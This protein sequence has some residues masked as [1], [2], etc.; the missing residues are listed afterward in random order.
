MLLPSGYD[1]EADMHLFQYQELKIMLDVNSGAIHVLDDVSALFIEKLRECDGDSSQVIAELRGEIAE[2]DLL[3]VA[4]ELAAAYE[5]QAAF[6]LAETVTYDISDL[7]IKALCLNVAHACNMRCRYCFASQGD[8]GMQPGLMTLQTGQQA[9]EFLIEASGPVKNLEVDFFGGE[10]LLNAVMLQELVRYARQR[11]E[12]CGKHFNFTLT[13]NAVLLDDKIIDFVINNDIGVI[14]SLDGRPRTNDLH[15]I[16][17]NG[18]GSYAQIVPRIKAMVD[19]QPV[20]CYIRGTFTRHNLDFSEDLQHIIDLGLESVS[21]E[22]AVGPNHEYSIQAEDLPQ[23]L[24]EYERLTDLLSHYRQKGQKIDFFHYNL[25]LQKGPCLAKR[26]SGCGAGVEYLV[27]TPEG[28]IYPCHQF[29]GEVEF[30][31]G[32]IF[33]ATL[34]QKIKHRFV[35]NRLGDKPTCQVCWARNFCGGG[36][37][38][39]AYH[40]NGDMSQ[41][42][43]VSCAMHRKRIEGAI[44]LEMLPALD[45]HRQ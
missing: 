31:M 39:N 24:A 5:A 17:N 32:N 20:S 33:T 16:L 42:D 27:V 4:A 3:E 12:E 15:R 2:Q 8:F 43:Q 19:R 1:F 34:D 30:K 44:Y 38:A 9:L 21:L 26:Q 41:P 7:P 25:D 40:A 35:H 28:D 6:S 11:E 22:P 36:C 10:P 37:H 18:E 45:L 13:T 14:L 23:V 29:V